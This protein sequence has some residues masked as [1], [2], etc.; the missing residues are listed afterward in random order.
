MEFSVAADDC[1]CEFREV[2]E[3][4]VHASVIGQGVARGDNHI[5]VL[6]TQPIS[7]LL[8]PLCDMIH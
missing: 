1:L 3:V 2:I 4:L 8:N 6:G 7:K 5:A